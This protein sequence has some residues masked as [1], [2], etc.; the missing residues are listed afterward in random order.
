MLF[1]N[2]AALS[3]GLLSA[4]L[5]GFL[6]APIMLARLSLEE[7]GLW[8]VTGSVA[9]YAGIADLGITQSMTRFVALYD[10]TGDRRG[11]AECVGLGLIT[12]TIIGALSTV[13]A[14][15]AAPFLSE[16]LGVLDSADMRIVLLS[17]MWIFT[18][19]GY[20]RVLSAVA[21]GL[22]RMVPP[23]VATVFNNS[24]N[25]AFSVAALVLS[26]N[27]VDYALANAAAGLV[28]VG[29]SFV[30]LLY[31]W[32]PPPVAM[33]SWARTRT[34]LSF[35]LKTQVSWL[36]GIVADSDK[37][38]LGIFID[39]RAVAAYEIGSRVVKA[40]RGIAALTVSA[41]IPTSTAYIVEH[42]REAIPDFYRRYTRRT[43][44]LSFPIFAV[45]CASAPFLLVAWLGDV[46]ESSGTVLLV[47]ALANAVNITTGVGTT[48]SIGD[49]R[50]GLAATNAVIAAV[51]GIVLTLALA[52]PF[53]LWG[54]L[55]GAALSITISALLF[56]RRFHR[57]YS[58]PLLDYVRAVGPP[59][60]LSLGLAAPF[61]V[62]GLVFGDF[63][64]TRAS[65][66]PALVIV[67]GVYS[68]L[69]WLSASWLGYLR[70]SSRRRSDAAASRGRRRCR[71][72]RRRP[73]GAR[74]GAWCASEPRREVFQ[75]RVGARYDQPVLDCTVHAVIGIRSTA[76]LRSVG[77]T[78]AGPRG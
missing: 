39:V 12:V 16:E 76:A 37:L 3:T 22:R 18:F 4:T 41:M 49:G 24:T 48:V 33:P 10:V 60:L 14:I 70:I 26:P 9:S 35:G 53:G 42:G 68:L 5:F 19:N 67:A 17:A 72:S 15:I 71:E 31:V 44:S 11:I 75:R 45:C 78:P 1:R 25:F 47:L 40:V 77:A 6:L 73:F 23:N 59:A 54:V 27:L 74:R 55:A 7:F 20:Q 38:I 2:T 21:I 58:I 64:Q 34:I 32:R 51:L 61:T 36:A 63:A 66:V 46:P 13:F 62:V 43:V 56:V 57:I 8:A 65:A 69:Y 50:P 30:A 29:S 28:G 52:P